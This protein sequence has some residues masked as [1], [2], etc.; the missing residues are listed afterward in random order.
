MSVNPP[1]RKQNKK[2]NIEGHA[3][4]LTCSTFRR[5]PLLTNDAWRLCLA[6]AIRAACD[7]HAVALWAYVFMPEHIHLLLKPRHAEYDLSAYEHDF[8][9]AS[10]RLVVKELKKQQS[11][12]L[13]KLKVTNRAGK[14]GYR[15]WQRGGGHDL[16]VW[17]MK[18]AVEKAE[19]CHW[20]PVKRRLV[21]SPE[22]WRFS[23]FKW[24]VLNDCAARDRRMG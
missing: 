1:H 13:E 7:K 4:F 9:L 15:F 22:Q 21:K 14:S 3:H 6:Q 19:Y 5:L 16:N 20:N 11:P 8:K 2:Y 23:S 18:K 17:N 24:L 10:S 12:L